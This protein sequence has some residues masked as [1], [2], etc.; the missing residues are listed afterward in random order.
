M[1]DDPIEYISPLEEPV[2]LW[3]RLKEFGTGVVQ[4]TLLERT[5]TEVSLT[6]PSK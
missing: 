4:V 6:G 5:E 1:R 2:L 3:V